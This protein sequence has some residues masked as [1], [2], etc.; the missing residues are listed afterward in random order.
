MYFMRA[1]SVGQRLPAMSWR[2]QVL[3]MGL[4]RFRVGVVVPLSAGRERVAQAT[5]LRRCRVAVNASLPGKSL[6]T[7]SAR[8]SLQPVYALQYEPVGKGKP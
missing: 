2:A 3:S 5:I 1:L 6:R 8:P 7:L 4:V